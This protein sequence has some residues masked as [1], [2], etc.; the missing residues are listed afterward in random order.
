MGRSQVVKGKSGER[1]LAAL[2]EAK[3]G[4]RCWRAPMSGAMR[5]ITGADLRG[6]IFDRNGALRGYSVECKRAA[7]AKW[8]E[9]W[10]KTKQ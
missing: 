7:K 9:W 5:E 6:P 1:E 4:E 8:P 3:T 10:A 2:I